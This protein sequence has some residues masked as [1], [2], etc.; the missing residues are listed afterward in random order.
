M[1]VLGCQGFE[2]NIHITQPGDNANGFPGPRASFLILETDNTC[3]L[4]FFEGN[5][6]SVTFAAGT[7][8]VGNCVGAADGA[9]FFRFNVFCH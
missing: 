2:E 1:V 5:G 7:Y 3:D 6:A 9:A 8:S 4:I